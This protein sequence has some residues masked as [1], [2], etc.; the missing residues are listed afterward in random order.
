MA[1]SSSTAT[2]APGLFLRAI[3]GGKSKNDKID[4]HK[5]AALL[6]GGLI[7]MAYVYSRTM[8]STRDLM[9]R[10]NLLMR[11]RAELV[12]HIQNTASQYNDRQRSPLP[13]IFSAV[14]AF[15][16]DGL[17]CQRMVNNGKNEGEGCTKKG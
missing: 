3:H 14:F 7:F 16:D 2:C 8:H 15:Q 13:R 6:K 4:S 5:I 9:R 17:S 10:R 11:K 1:I 12:A